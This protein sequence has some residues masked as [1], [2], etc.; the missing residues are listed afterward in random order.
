MGWAKSSH[1]NYQLSAIGYQYLCL[2]PEAY[3]VDVHFTAGFLRVLKH[4][5]LARLSPHFCSSVAESNISRPKKCSLLLVIG[6]LSFVVGYI[7]DDYDIVSTSKIGFQR[8]MDEQIFCL[9]F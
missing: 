9:S 4:C 1:F 7:I 3:N 6:S 2:K 8:L 5:I